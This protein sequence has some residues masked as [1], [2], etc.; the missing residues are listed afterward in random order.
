MG[1]T[2]M[3][4]KATN[5]LLSILEIDLS[6]EKQSQHGNATISI[7]HCNDPEFY[8]NQGKVMMG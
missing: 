8:K 3:V 2:I 7:S 4:K 5:W 1:L 6:I